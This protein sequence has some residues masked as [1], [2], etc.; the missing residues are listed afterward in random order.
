MSSNLPVKKSKNISSEIVVKKSKF[1]SFCFWLSSEDAVKAKISE[2][3]K[4]YHS[5]NHLVYAYRLKEKGI[6]KEKFINDKEPA[7]S[8]GA[9]L[10]YLLQ[11]K[12]LENCL[13]V[14]VRYFGGT[15]LGV[16]GLIRAYTQAGQGAIA[17]NLIVDNSK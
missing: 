15:K 3:K 9:P 16:G 6:L 17:N 11:K 2:L 5:A 12:E 10:L 4:E 1:L 14:V 13:L 8:A 7:A